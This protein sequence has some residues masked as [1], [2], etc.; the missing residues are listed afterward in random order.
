MRRLIDFRGLQASI[1]LSG[2]VLTIFSPK[3]SAQ[4]ISQP[5]I[6]ACSRLKNFHAAAVEINT[7]EEQAAGPFTP[8]GPPGASVPAIQLPAH[9]LVTGIIDRRTGVGGKP[10]GI[11]FELR[12]PTDWNH[13]F[14]FQG[15]G[16]TN[17][18]VPAAVGAVKGPAA[19]TRGF[20]VVTQDGGHEGADSSFGEDQQARIDMEYRSYERVT[21]LAKQ[22]VAAFY[23]QPADRAYFM[24]CSEGGREAL[25]ISQRMP[26]EYDGIVAG[27]P[28]F[29]LGVSFMANADRITIAGV[30]PKGKNGQPDYGKA[31][32]DAEL[33][34]FETA[35]EN[36][37]DAADGLKDGMIDNPTACRPHLE[38]LI[39]K[40]GAT[41]GTCL[42]KKQVTA[43]R[44][45]F[46]GGEPDGHDIV[47]P[48]YFYDTAVD[49]PSWKHKLAGYGGL[50]VSGVN[51]VQGL[52]I[53]PYDPSYD[54]SA[55]NFVKDGARFDE[56][57]ALNRADGVMYSS[58]TQH[59][60]KLLV[61][62]GVSDQAFSA[63]ELVEYYKK[64]GEANGGDTA[65]ADFARLFLVPGMT[66]CRGGKSLDDFDPLQAVV[67]WVETNAAPAR[68]IAT[69]AAFPGRSRPLCPFP[70][71]SRYKGSGS[72]DEA[73]NFECRLPDAG[74]TPRVKR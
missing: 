43:L 49:L 52:F 42:S 5:A 45:I 16:G 18:V 47:S 33:K 37:C 40:R 22:V 20:A 67:D 46:D 70:K 26:L 56:V 17:G 30:S 61:Y 19:L 63:K 72:T 50:T 48:G 28:G 13:R 24:G 58:F 29:R 8:K 10:Y 71:Q 4:S 51:S 36:E 57:G 59:G 69:G 65:V 60:G 74:G 54:D 11:R 7:A 35:I 1:V 73:G 6:S 64:L 39:C 55:I 3:L 14:L 27:D 2:A 41:A 21:V 32:N 44:T 53:T 15:G 62:T 25:L 34:L 12:L 9:C 66:H 68:I 31:F 23:G 38:R